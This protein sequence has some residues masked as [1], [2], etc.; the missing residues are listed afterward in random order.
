MEVLSLTD[1]I[2]GSALAEVRFDSE[3]EK[4]QIYE[5]GYAA[6]I[7]HFDKLLMERE[8]SGRPLVLNIPTEQELIQLGIVTALKRGMEKSGISSAS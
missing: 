5:L 2:D 4:D 6:A 3:E 8:E 7:E 1:N